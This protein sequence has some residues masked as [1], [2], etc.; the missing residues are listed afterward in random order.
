[1]AKRVQAVLGTSF[2]LDDHQVTVSASIGIAIGP[3]DG[4]EPDQLLKN[5][6]LALHRAKRDGHGAYRFFEPGM[7]ELMQHRHKLERDLR[8]ALHH[9]EFEV[10]YQP[11]LNLQSG[12]IAGFE[13]LL[14]W[15]HPER[16]LV[17]P[18]EFVPLAEDTGLIVPLGEW[19]LRQ[20]CLEAA[21]WPKHLRV[22]VNLSVAQF[23]SGNVRQATIAALGASQLA[24]GRLEL[25]ITESVLLQESEGVAEVLGKLQD[26][27]VGI[28]LDDFGT[29][30]SSLS[31]LTLIRF[32]K[33]KIDKMFVRELRDEPNSSLAVLRSVVALARSL[34]ITTIAEGVETKEQLALVRQEGCTEAQGYYIGEPRPAREIPAILSAQKPKASRP[35]RPARRAS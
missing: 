27:G 20:A 35:A 18:S 33:I 7:D 4:T 31:Y 3:T 5:A 32:D 17:S 13:A 23:R 28:A 25:E 2:D 29:G 8:S 14:R 19:T 16:G 24:P 30:Y 22:A 1:L 9:G 6:D 21:T 11:Q 12:E 10:Y 26:I 15:N 34:G